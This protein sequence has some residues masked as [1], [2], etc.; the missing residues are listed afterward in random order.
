MKL[1]LVYILAIITIGLSA[2]TSSDIQDDIEETNRIISNLT[3]E[4]ETLNRSI[5]SKED[6]IRANELEIKKINTE[7]KL[8]ELEIDKYDY[9]IDALE[10]DIELKQKDIIK[11]EEERNILNLDIENTLNEI[12]LIKEQIEQERVVLNSIIEDL[13]ELLIYLFKNEKES[14]LLKILNNVNNSEEKHIYKY[15]SILLENDKNLINDFEYQINSLDT[16]RNKL[17]EAYVLLDKQQIELE[18]IIEKLYKEE[19]TINKEIIELN[20]IKNNYS[21]EFGSLTTNRNNKKGR[22]VELETEIKNLKITSQ[23]KENEIKNFINKLNQLMSDKNAAKKREEKLN[24]ESTKESIIKQK[25]K[26]TWPLDGKIIS[27]YGIQY[28]KQ[29]GTKI[30]N[31]SISIS[32]KE[33]NIVRNIHDGVVVKI[34]YMPGFDNF[35]IIDHGDQTFS[36]YSNVKNIAVQEDEFINSQQQIAVVAKSDKTING[37]NTYLSFQMFYKN[38]SVNP[39]EWLKK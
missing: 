35:I 31:I 3:L 15:I 23:N 6:I 2:Q 18:K 11:Q 10:S 30:D 27:K 25:G 39:E 8:I 1:R 36:I 5:N 37:E 4:I 38:K 34:D 9:E 17:E 16:S 13:D 33:N 7:I 24:K 28:N 22:I 19:N 26:L 32:A 20:E 29:L 14:I 12:E 21:K